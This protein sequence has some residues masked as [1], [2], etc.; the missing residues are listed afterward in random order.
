MLFIT[1]ELSRT[2]AVVKYLLYIVYMFRWVMSQAKKDHG[3]DALA[4]YDGQ[5]VCIVQL[6]CL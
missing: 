4:K 6:S 5:Y 2:L 1:T 3:S